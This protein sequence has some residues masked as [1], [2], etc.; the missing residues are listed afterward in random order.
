MCTVQRS[1][2]GLRTRTISITIHFLSV[3]CSS[4]NR[5][6]AHTRHRFLTFL[7]VVY[8]QA[9]WCLNLTT[10]HIST[11]THARAYIIRTL[12]QSPYE[13]LFCIVANLSF[14][15]FLRLGDESGNNVPRRL[16]DQCP[17]NLGLPSPVEYDS[18]VFV[19]DTP[20]PVPSPMPAHRHHITTTTRT[21]TTTTTTL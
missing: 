12:A 5:S 16:I 4:T 21:T 15:R 20:L 14:F 7:N 10:R 9:M 6:R 19:L 3:R 13:K 11:N 8:R 18:A 17:L 1:P 2:A